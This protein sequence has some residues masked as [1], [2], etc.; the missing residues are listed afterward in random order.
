LAA[1]IDCDRADGATLMDVMNVGMWAC[2]TMFPRGAFARYDQLIWIAQRDSLLHRKTFGAF[3]DEHHVIAGFHHTTRQANGIFDVA[4]H[5][6]CSGLEGRTIHEY[7]VEL[8]A[9]VEVQMR[10]GAGVKYWIVFE[11]NDCGFDCIGC[12]T[13]ALE[14]FPAFFKSAS[15]S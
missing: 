5:G 13:A 2:V 1:R 15:A 4:E 12:R 6:N 11:N 14:Y 7:G 3:A 10:A 9:A 8:D